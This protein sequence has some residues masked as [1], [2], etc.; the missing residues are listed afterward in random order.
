MSM[1]RRKPPPSENDAEGFVYVLECTNPLSYGPFGPFHDMELEACLSNVDTLDEEERA[2]IQRF[3]LGFEKSRKWIES[4]IGKIENKGTRDELIN[5][6]NE[7]S[8][9]S[10][11]FGSLRLGLHVPWT[12]PRTIDVVRDRNAGEMRNIKTATV[13]ARKDYINR[14][15]S[16]DKL[17]K[18]GFVSANWKKISD[19]LVKEDLGDKDDS[20]TR[21]KPIQQHTI[22]RYVNEILGE[23]ADSCA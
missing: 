3:I 17:A 6:I 4:Y 13:I 15:Y 1:K 22:R 5:A 8:F 20:G 9:H 2:R 21:K 11:V 23:D 19:A 10:Y 12:D 18:R 14:N 7:L 16:K